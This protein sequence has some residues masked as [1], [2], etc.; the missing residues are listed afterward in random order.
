MKTAS[1]NNETWAVASWFIRGCYILALIVIGII[2]TKFYFEHKETNDKL[3]QLNKLSAQIEASNN[4]M[5]LLSEKAARISEQTPQKL[6]I[7]Q[8]ADQISGLTLKERKKFLANLPHDPEITSYQTTLTFF[9]EKAAAE[10]E[11]MAA[12]WDE[13]PED[14]RET[15]QTSS[16]FLQGDHPF[17]D[18]RAVLKQTKV[19]D[20]RTKPDIHWAAR[21]IEAT[22]TNQVLLSN[23]HITK[24]LRTEET[25]IA[26]TQGNMLEDYL[27]ITV[28]A[29]AFIGFCIFIP[30]D[31]FIQRMMKRIV[32]KT[33]LAESQ[34]R[35]AELADRAKSDFLANMSHEIRT[36][37]NGVMGMAELLLRTDLSQKQKTFADVIVKSGTSLLTIINDILDF[38]KIDAGRMELDPAPFSLS[39]AIEDVA[40]L[41]AAKVTEKDLELIV[42]IS[43]ELPEQLVGDVGRIRQIVTNLVGNAVKFTEQGHVFIEVDGTTDDEVAKLKFSVNDTGMGIEPEKLD[44]IFDKFS[45]VDES[46]TRRHEGTG[47]GLAIACSLVELMD[48]DIGVESILG[49]GSTF[50]FEIPLP[51]AEDNRAVNKVSSDISGARVLVVDGNE[52]NRSALVEKLVSWGFESA[53]AGSC[54]EA[55]SALLMMRDTGIAPDCVILDYN[56]PDQTGAELVT[57]IRAE[58][59]ISQIPIIM[60]SSV[61]QMENGENLSSLGIQGH[62]VK[63]VRSSAI[64]EFVVGTLREAKSVDNEIVS[65]VAMA[66]QMGNARS[67][68]ADTPD[69]NSEPMFEAFNE[70]SEI[71]EEASSLTVLQMTKQ[72]EPIEVEH[73]LDVEAA[74]DNVPEE[75]RRHNSIQKASI[76]SAIDELRA[77]ADNSIDILLAEDNEVNQIVFRQIVESAGYSYEIANNGQEA[78]ELYKKHNPKVICMDVSMPIMN[79]HE[80][81][82]QIRAIE[83]DLDLHTPIIGVTAHAIKGDMEKC[84]EA[85]MDDYL[86]KPVS[87]EKLENKICKWINASN[88]EIDLAT[89]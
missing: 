60:L 12:S 10:F 64:R 19:R 85:G 53:G 25:S 17:R 5:L 55:F 62:L 29:L 9:Q 21:T 71:V 2:C 30:I 82:R 88:G 43:P 31:F 38:S 81:T 83:R 16:R 80:A 89:G 79:G 84:F 4:A 87:P 63:P 70:E 56:M 77:N 24:L 73:T 37:M 18:H 33:E 57:S 46:A 59:T 11:M 48:G 47:L 61:D 42:R 72:Q 6:D 32:E 13:L 35:R 66:K 41:V 1:G 68:S 7:S 51:I 14:L 44:R 67:V 75:E 86:S 26:A 20:A 40:A 15:I 28:C 65:G 22:F 39:E 58:N 78:I 49:E 69:E 76:V 36:P 34:G 54:N 3:A 23:Q 52:I 50:W 27:L 8:Y 45:Q 74:D